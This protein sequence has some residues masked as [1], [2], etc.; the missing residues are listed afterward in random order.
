MKLILQNSTL[1]FKDAGIVPGT[2]DTREFCKNAGAWSVAQATPS[3]VDTQNWGYSDFV[4]VEHL[5][6]V[7]VCCR[8]YNNLPGIL[9]FATKD[10]SSYL[11]CEDEGGGDA[12]LGMRH[13]TT[14]NIPTGAKY[15]II[16]SNFVAP[17]YV[18]G[19]TITLV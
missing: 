13:F 8:A 14:F 11:G 6:D 4:E 12:A 1:T 5:S 17:N 16:Q 3:F 2:Y 9:Y 7:N 10:T 15:A 18:S 19:S